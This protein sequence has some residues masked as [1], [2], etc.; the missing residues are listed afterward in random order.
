MK[1]YINQL[2]YAKAQCER[3]ISELNN[4]K[5][6]NPNIMKGA[7]VELPEGVSSPEFHPFTQSLQHLPG[8]KV[9]LYFN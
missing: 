4:K 3:R 6:Q 1:R 7:E 9:S 5:E 2:T 8:R